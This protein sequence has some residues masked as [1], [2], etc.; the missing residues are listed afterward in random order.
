MHPLHPHCSGRFR[1]S[2]Y[3]TIAPVIMGA[4][5]AG[6]Q[7]EDALEEEE[8]EPVDLASV[9]RNLQ[10]VTVAE[11]RLENVRRLSPAPTK[12]GTFTNPFTGG[13]LKSHDWVLLTTPYGTLFCQ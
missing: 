11:A 1:A 7:E 2:G 9:R 5:T 4:A 8:A 12:Y 10:N 3:P 6:T 13:G